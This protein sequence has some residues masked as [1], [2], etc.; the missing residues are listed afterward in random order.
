MNA[1]ELPSMGLSATARSAAFRKL[2]NL[3]P[4]EQ[5]LRPGRNR[6]GDWTAR[7][8]RHAARRPDARA[9]GIGLEVESRARTPRRRASPASPRHRRDPAPSDRPFQRGPRLGMLL[10]GDALEV[11]EAAQHRLVRAQ[12]LGSPAADRLA[13]AVRQNAVMSATVETMRGTS[14]PAARRPSPGGTGGRRFSAQR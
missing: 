9:E 14:R 13:H 10:G 1:M 12:L 3:L 11:P 7:P 4:E 8:R 2:S 6:P 5:R